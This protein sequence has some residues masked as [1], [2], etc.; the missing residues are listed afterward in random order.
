VQ[1]WREMPEEVRLNQQPRQAWFDQEMHERWQAGVARRLVDTAQV[2]R[3]ALN[4]VEGI[5]GR[6]GTGFQHGRNRPLGLVIAGTNM[7]AVDSLVSYLMGFDPQSLVYLK[8]A[9]EA[10]LG[11]NDIR[12]LH[13]YQEESGELKLCQNVAALRLD[14]PFRVITNIKGEDPDPF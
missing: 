6:E 8:M 2:I 14:P 4:I 1:S 3:P 5:V 11:S 13:I 12:Q 9:A 10:G 7:V